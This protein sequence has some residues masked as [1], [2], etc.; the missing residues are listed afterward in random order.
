MAE[1]NLIY[2]KELPLD[3]KSEFSA[4]LSES[5]KIRE[6]FLRKP[7]K[8]LSTNL[9]I[10]YEPSAIDLENKDKIENGKIEKYVLKTIK[11]L[12]KK[13]LICS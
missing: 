1:L 11:E 12:N 4:N 5:N 8:H 9:E 2:F 7:N 6:F 3:Q 13:N 10:D